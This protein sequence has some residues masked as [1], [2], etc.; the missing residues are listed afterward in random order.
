MQTQRQEQN[1]FRTKVNLNILLT[2]N[3]DTLIASVLT[4]HYKSGCEG[5]NVIEREREK[6]KGYSCGIPQ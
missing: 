3:G 5:E 4:P 6:D 2:W 1:G